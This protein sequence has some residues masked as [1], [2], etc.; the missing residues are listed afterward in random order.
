M[1]RRGRADL[2][3]PLALLDRVG[4]PIAVGEGGLRE[5]LVLEL[6]GGRHPV[7]GRDGASPEAP[8]VKR[9]LAAPTPSE[10]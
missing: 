4:Q 10:P 7:S 5:G 3:T 6:A 1:T 2:A 9:T 8:P